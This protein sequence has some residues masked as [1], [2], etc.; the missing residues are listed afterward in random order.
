MTSFS[1]TAA[2]AILTMEMV[3][4]V[5]HY[6]DNPSQLGAHLTQQL[7]ELLGGGCAVLVSFT[8]TKG[9]DYRV[10]GFS[11]NRKRS[12]ADFD[13]FQTLIRNH[14]KTKD[15]IVVALDASNASYQDLLVLGFNNCVLIPLHTQKARVG[16]LLAFNVMEVH[17]YHNIL[18]SIESISLLIATI[19]ATSLSYE[20][21]ERIIE[22]RT[23]ELQVAKEKAEVASVAKSEFLANMSHEIRT[24]MNGI[25]GMTDLL[26]MS[27]LSEEQREYLTLSKKATQSL[28]QIINDILEFSKL[29]AGKV[30]IEEKPF[31]ISEMVYDV[32]HLFEISIRQKPVNISVDLAPE[33]Y[34]Q[35][36]GDGLKLRQVLSNLVGNA[37]KFTEMGQIKIRV[38]LM[39][40]NED[41]TTYQFEVSD[42][43]IGIP[44]EQ[45][46]DLFERFI[47]ADSSHKKKYQ[48]TG[49]GLAISRQMVELLGGTMWFESEEKEGSQFYFTCRVRAVKA[50]EPDKDLEQSIDNGREPHKQLRVL[51]V[52]DDDI[53]RFLV[54]VLLKKRDIVCTS[55]GNGQEALDALKSQIVDLILMDIQ[56]PVLDGESAARLIRESEK[57]KT[58]PIIAMTAYAL[59]GDRE[60][61]LRAGI[62]DYISKPIDVSLFDSMINHWTEVIIGEKVMDHKGRLK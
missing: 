2:T 33:C 41:V 53:S 45:Q 34:K 39:T 13:G 7:Q 56:M 14:A 25:M 52:D 17:A 4:Q 48:G 26:L 61:F 21:Q 12:V 32:V 44:K 8:A 29:E 54:S 62:D 5:I 49:L 1:Q 36:L 40:R 16:M 46:S 37:V 60:R 27:E 19:L 20:E 55:V 24:P 50:S 28:L 10:I 47:Q 51:V 11:P 22:E 59:E 38:G 31:V 15:P 30:K 9:E 57:D 42:T 3:R 58:T 35:V 18:Q 23:S 6:A 43:G